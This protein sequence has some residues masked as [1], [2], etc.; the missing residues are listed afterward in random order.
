MWKFRPA[1]SYLVAALS[2]LGRQNEAKDEMAIQRDM[3]RPQAFQGL[4]RFQEY[5][6]QVA[7]YENEAITTRLGQIWQ[8]A[9]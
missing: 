7:P 3:G 5:V 8:E 9:E 6:Q 1:R 4:E 2:A